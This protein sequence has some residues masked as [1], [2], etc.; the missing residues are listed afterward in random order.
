MNALVL[1]AVALLSGACCWV[2]GWCASE[3]SHLRALR[4]RREKIERRDW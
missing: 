1:I 2:L 3:A 4:E